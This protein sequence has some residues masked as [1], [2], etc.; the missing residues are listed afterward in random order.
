ME[1]SHDFRYVLFDG[2]IIDPCVTLEDCSASFR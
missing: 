1:F 2:A